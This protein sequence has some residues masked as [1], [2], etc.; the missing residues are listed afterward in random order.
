MFAIHVIQSQTFESEKETKYIIEM[1]G[2][3]MQCI[4]DTAYRQVKSKKKKKSHNG[5]DHRSL[6]KNVL[7][8]YSLTFVK[9]SMQ[10]VD[11]VATAAAAA[12]AFS[13]FWILFGCQNYSHQLPAVAMSG[14]PLNKFVFM[15]NKINVC[16][17]NI[18]SWFMKQ[19][20]EA[21]A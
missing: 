4:H 19:A 10:M 5:C 21:I 9:F 13:P 6:Y 15:F 7:F 8:Y 12:A 1:G 18:V 14:R 20:Y 3:S 11:E 17:Q 16:S 2:G